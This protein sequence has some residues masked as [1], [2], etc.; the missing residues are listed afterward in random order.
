MDVTI[1]LLPDTVE[2]WRA[3]LSYS[4]LD[5]VHHLP[6]QNEVPYTELYTRNAGVKVSYVSNSGGLN[7]AA[8]LHADYET[9]SGVE[10]VIDNGSAGRFLELMRFAMYSS[11]ILRAG[12]RGSAEWGRIQGRWSLEASSDFIYL[13]SAYIYPYRN[14]NT[15]GLDINI[16]AAYTL[17]N[18]DVLFKALLEAGR[19]QSFGADITIPENY[20]I[21]KLYSF[22][23][24]RRERLA[25]SSFFGGAS[26]RWEREILN[27]SLFAL[28]SARY[29][30]MDGGA[31]ALYSTLTIG[32]NF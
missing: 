25:S 3:G 31:D 13:N 32:F 28:A 12:A 8:L 18:E 29:L 5:L 1:N 17:R 6:N 30:R 26:L 20:T 11:D 7:Y 16:K 21:E 10:I 4:I 27:Y 23:T 2:G 24:H 19:Y 15:K 14:L 9:R 22:Y